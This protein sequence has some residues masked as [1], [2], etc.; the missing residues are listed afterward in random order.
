M[1]ALVLL[2]IF[3]KF[4][5][6]TGRSLWRPFP[7]TKGV[8][9]W[10]HPAGWGPSS[11]RRVWGRWV[12]WDRACAVAGAWGP[13]R[14]EEL[15]LLIDWSW[16]TDPTEAETEVLQQPRP[17]GWGNSGRSSKNTQRSRAKVG[18]SGA[19]DGQ[20]FGQTTAFFFFSLRKYRNLFLI[21]FR[22]TVLENEE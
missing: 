2:N 1:D 5:S 3:S 19:Q 20:H 4:I 16:W 8:R 21:T 9:Q 13:D 12:A 7:E 10:S 6:A 18:G 14:R 17:R 22:G 11:A 15:V